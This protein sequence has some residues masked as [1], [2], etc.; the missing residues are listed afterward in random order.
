MYVGDRPDN[1]ARPAME[2]GMK[3]CLIRRGPWG[4]ILNIPAVFDQCLLPYRFAGRTPGPGCQAQRGVR[5]TW[6]GRG[7]EHVETPT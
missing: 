1:D 6:R 7:G 2:A 5:P 4:H 3:T